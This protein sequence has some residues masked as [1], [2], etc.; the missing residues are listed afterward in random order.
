MFFLI[1]LLLF[2]CFGCFSASA[3]FLRLFLFCFCC[4]SAYAVFLLLLF[5]C[6]CCFSAYAVFL[7]LLF[8]CFLCFCPSALCFCCFSALAAARLSLFVFACPFVCFLTFGSGVLLGGAA[9]SQPPPAPRNLHFISDTRACHDIN[10]LWSTPRCKNSNQPY[11]PPV[12]VLFLFTVSLLSAPD[13]C[14]R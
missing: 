11:M 5:F 7:L 9:P 2:F 12:L 14:D 6:F 8:F 13:C 3:A 1:L 4:F 10:I